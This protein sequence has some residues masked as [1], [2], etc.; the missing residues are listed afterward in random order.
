MKLDALRKRYGV[1][2]SL[3]EGLEE[4]AANP[5]A[6]L[7]EG[8]IDGIGNGRSFVREIGYGADRM[9]GPHDFRG[10][11]ML[12]GE[13]VAM[14]TG[15]AELEYAELS[16]AVFLDTETTG[17]GLGVGT[18]V[19][20]V[21]AGFFD[22]SHFRVR[23]YF[24]GGPGEESAFLD[25]LG[26]FLSQFPAVVTFN[27]KAFDWPLLETRYTL[28]RRPPPLVDPPHLDLLHPARRVWKRRLESCALTALER[29]V[30]GL[31]R[32]EQDVAGW[33]I[34]ALYFD[35]LRRGDG[36]LL[37]GVFYHNLHDILS[38]AILAI[39]LQRIIQDPACGLLQD[40]ID[41]LSVARVF[42]RAGDSSGAVQ[43][44]EEALARGI[45]GQWIED[46]LLG[47]GAIYKRRR[48]WERAVVVWEQLADGGGRGA[49][50][51]LV[52][53]AKYFEHGERDFMQALDAVQQ[54]IT[55][56]EL[57]ASALW[58]VDRADLEHRRARLLNRVYRNRSWVGSGV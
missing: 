52:E 29:N 42:E 2:S 39:H 27:G 22:G 25:D 12:A 51:G 11:G 13:P 15:D 57:S 23:Q 5:V 33:Q 3:P 7:L 17:L 32:S 48:S 54:A 24:L 47:L 16:R 28:G 4:T 20:L 46:C 30:L 44:Y 9:H 10:V 43:C 49:V 56:L 53:M 8:S 14:L 40:P 6:T 21:G 38:L 31:V 18:Y 1:T 58:P 45:G 41:F 55:L 37:A 26:S 34:P 50:L 35:Y 19:F 36:A